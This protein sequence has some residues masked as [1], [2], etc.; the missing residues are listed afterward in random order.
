MPVPW[1]SLHVA[2]P[3][4]GLWSRRRG[5]A[6]VCLPRPPQVLSSGVETT[7][8]LGDPPPP[9]TPGRVERSGVKP[10]HPHESGGYDR[11]RYL[12][13]G[14]STSPRRGRVSGRDDVFSGGYASPARP[15]VVSSGA[16]AEPRH[17]HGRGG[18][19]RKRYLRDSGKGLLLIPSP[20]VR[21]ASLSPQ[22]VRSAPSSGLFLRR[23]RRRSG[24]GSV[25]R[26]RRTDR[27]GPLA[28]LA[29]GA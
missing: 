4:A 25:R 13:G 19:D 11:D 15:P 23:S 16:T 17:L 20:E 26:D 22:S 6:G 12:R 9:P 7:C 2:P 5:F 27:R 10:R 21:Y 28:S 14:L 8:F 24:R 3:G 18:H 29:E 1:R